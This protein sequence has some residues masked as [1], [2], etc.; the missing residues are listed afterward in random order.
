M[1]PDPAI[2]VTDLQ[3]AN[4]KLIFEEKK[5]SAYYPGTYFLKVHSHHFKDK[6]PKS[7]EKQ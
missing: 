4:K 5:I 6:K 3:E 7:S 2:F 1:D